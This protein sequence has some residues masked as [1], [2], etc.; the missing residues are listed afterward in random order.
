MIPQPWFPRAARLCAG[1]L[2]GLAGSL[3]A[4][5]PSPSPSPGAVPN[6]QILRV[7]LFLDGS[8][9]KPGVI[10]GKWGEFTGKALARYQQ[11]QGKTA[12][13]EGAKAPAEF[14]LPL[15]DSKPVQIAYRITPEDEK[16]IGP[17]PK[18]H[19]GQAKADRLP[20]ENLLEL[21]AEKFHCRR[22]F[23]LQLNPGYDWDKA[24]AGDEVQVPN[25]ATPF[26]LQAVIDLK[27]KTEEAEKANELK[28]E[29]EKSP[30]EQFSAEVDVAAKIMEL[31]QDGKLVGSYPITPGS[32]SLPAPVGEWFIKG[33]A[34]MPTFRWDQEML[35]RGKRSDESYQLP[36]GPNNPVGI[37]WMELSNKGSGIHGTEAPETIGRSTSHGCIRLANWDALE[38][39]QKVLPGVHIVIR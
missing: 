27:T 24:K 30:N 10:D 4:A 14:D 17:L 22:E 13:E 25:V 36:P 12:P 19:P 29:K 8:A 26:E 28:T 15:D 21:V 5:S 16:F 32:K 23:L 7:Q 11:A 35:Q 2:L 9:F 1:I 33:F 38:F 6:E 18:D 34:W 31:K 3:S 37:V 39:G 20:Y